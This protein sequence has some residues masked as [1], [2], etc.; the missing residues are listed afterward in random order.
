MNYSTRAK[1][2][3]K[4]VVDGDIVACKN[5]IRACQRF[6]DDLDKDWQWKYQSKYAEHVC[7]FMEAG[8]RHNKGPLAGQL[9]IL[10]DWQCFV[11]CNIYGWRKSDNDNIKR[12]R[13]VLLQIA[14]KSGKTL[15]ASGLAIY[16]MIF[17]E[18]G[19]EVYSLATNRDQS[20]IAWTGAEDMIKASVDQVKSQ[21]KVVTNQISNANTRSFYKPLSKES[22]SLDGLNPSMAIFD[23]AAQYS[24][25]NLVEVMESGTGARDNFLLLFITTAAFSRATVYYENKQYMEDILKGISEND[26]WF[27]MIFELDEGDD[28]TDES[29]W[30]KAN[31]NLG[32]SVS[33][34]WLRERVELAKSIKSKK[35]EVLVK[36]FN[37]FTNAETNWI[38]L[39]EWQKNQG[40][41]LKDGD[42]F[43]GMDLSS[44]RDLTALTFVWH[45]G[46]K[47]SVDF[48]TFLP[49]ASMSDVAVNVRPL[50]DQA[51]EDGE[52]ILTS[53]KS[54][55]YQEVLD[56]IV[57]ASH[58]YNL[59][60]VG[61][62]NHNAN[63][64]V[65][66]MEDKGIPCVSVG[67]GM[68]ALT[69]AAKAT[70][71]LIAEEK[72]AHN[73]SKFIDWQ[74]ECCTLYTD[75]NQN[76]K[77]T[78]DDTN[79]SH[80]I[81]SIIAMIMAMSMVNDLEQPK[82]FNFEFFEFN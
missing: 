45:N 4:S 10:E 56:Y 48:K 67:Q 71:I 77:I 60:M 44:T 40:E 58:N 32:V 74:L 46:D 76:I 50:Y 18:Q 3:A 53:G 14:R 42:L 59:K 21:F 35:N 29:V 15:F 34:E 54:V 70:E 27:G 11:L 72:F 33:L 55:D 61:Y 36:N 28:W 2:Y 81:D 37:V 17:G 25:R 66:Q 62:D 51:R 52:L 9:L 79:K 49:K 22:K 65:N 8:I 7:S 30:I 69:A 57:D 23:E 64:L 6:I 39:S 82:E 78:K 20:R 19:G 68:L 24:D 38:D 73:G 26:R 5:V 12:F 16:E 63:W 31:P 1:R 47:Y 43:I 13:Y 41:V 75:K 80:K